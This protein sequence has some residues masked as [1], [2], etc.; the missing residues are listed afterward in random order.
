[1]TKSKDLPK[2]KIE[3]S[4]TEERLKTD[5]ITLSS[6]QLR[7][8]LSA[9]KWFA[10][11]LL[12][13]RK[14]KLNKNQLEYIREIQRSNERAIALVSDLLQVSRVSEGKLHL[15]LAEADLP[16]LI[17]EVIDSNRSFLTNKG[18]VLHLEILNGPLPNIFVDKAKIRRVAQN[19]LLNAIKYTPKGGQ[20]NVIL[21]NN[22]DDVICAISDNGVGIPADQQNKIFERFYRATNVLRIEPDGTGLGLFI[23]KSLVEAHRG[24]VWFESEEGKGT[25]VS[26]SLPFRKK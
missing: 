20:I 3:A 24:K 12:T 16:T 21:K 19:I 26:F 15:D 4:S 6:H 11:I 7:T 17:E 9:I 10:E 22:S 8:P 23:A 1:M 2:P 13:Q 25:T 14:G 18:I 5:F